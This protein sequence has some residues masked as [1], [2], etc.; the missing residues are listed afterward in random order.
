MS[1]STTQVKSLMTAWMSSTSSNCCLCH[2]YVPCA[3][4]THNCLQSSCSRA[5]LLWFCGSNASP[6]RAA[7]PPSDTKPPHTR[8]SR[9]GTHNKSACPSTWDATPMTSIIALLNTYGTGLQHMPDA[10]QKG[11]SSTLMETSYVMTGRRHKGAPNPTI[12]PSTFALV[13][14]TPP[15]VLECT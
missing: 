6:K 5:P 14:A 10:P 9:D 7:C 4:H 1:C 11:T 3:D 8:L 13:V 12:T 15:T 2:L